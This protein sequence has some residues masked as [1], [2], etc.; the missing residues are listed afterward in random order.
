MGENFEKNSSAKKTV[1]K[2]SVIIKALTVA[3]IV[4][5][6]VLVGV[7]AM[8][9]VNGNDETVT[10]GDVNLSDVSTTNPVITT[11]P[12]I[13]NVA[14]TTASTTSAVTTTQA[15]RQSMA[16]ANEEV[17]VRSG[18]STDDDLV[19]VLAAG[20]GVIYLGDNGDGWYRVMYDSE[21]CYISA[22]YLTVQEVATTLPADTP[23]NGLKTID[24]SYPRWYLVIVD[25]TRQMPEGYVPETDYVADS[26][27]ELDARVVPYF[28]A[29]YNA[30]LEDGIELY[31]NSGYRSYETQEENLNALVEEYMYD[32]D[33]EEEEAYEMAVKEILPAGCSEHNLG[34]AMD[35]GD[36]DESFAETEAY[37]W[38]VENA[39]NYGFIE[40]YTEEN[41]DITGI[42][43]EPWHWRFV[44]PSHAKK[45][46]AAGITLEEYLQYYNI[47]Y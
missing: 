23:Q 41:Q 33:V 17:N 42:I 16:Y 6:V 20:E 21:V 11:L 47:Q 28:D 27:E 12:D 30:A 2:A 15:P 5:A 44:G 46:K 18:P 8:A 32:Y 9:L 24:V 3:C 10:S 22:E 7:I 45:I 26:E 29:M 37:A 1:S 19:G 43:P 39:H 13:N 34:L 31:A 38:L 36:I 35:I 25:R 4:C 14:P 40:R